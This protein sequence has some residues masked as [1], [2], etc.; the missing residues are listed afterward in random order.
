MI[1]WF[2]DLDVQRQGRIVVD[3]P[4][5]NAGFSNLLA[6]GL[7][8][9]CPAV[10]EMFTSEIAK[11]KEINPAVAPAYQERIEKIPF[12]MIATD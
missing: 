7:L 4:K 8:H 3:F 10:Q 1:L 11:R 6:Y 2:N 9:I 5:N 12:S